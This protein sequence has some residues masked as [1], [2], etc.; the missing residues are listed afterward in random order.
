[1]A[2]NKY[3]IISAFGQTEKKEKFK[4]QNTLALTNNT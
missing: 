3:S 4:K 2:I 1:M